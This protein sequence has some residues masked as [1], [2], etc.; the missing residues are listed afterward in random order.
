[1]TKLLTS[2]DIQAFYHPITLFCS[3]H[4]SQ[5]IDVQYFSLSLDSDQSHAIRPRWMLGRYNMPRCDILSEFK[6]ILLPLC[7]H[8]Y[9]V[10]RSKTYQN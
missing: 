10:L 5:R 9:T 6:N 8:L 1:M 3:S 7:Q 4:P 2:S